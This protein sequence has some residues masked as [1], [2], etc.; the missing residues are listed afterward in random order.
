MSDLSDNYHSNNISISALELGQVDDFLKIEFDAF[1]DSFRFIYSN[2]RDAAYNIQRQEI[3]DNLIS[4]R[5]YN[6]KDGYKVVGTI[7]LVTRENSKNYKKKFQ[8]FARYLGILRAIKAY[9]LDLMDLPHLDFS[10]VYID[11]VAVD[12]ENRRK[13]I[14]ARMLSFAEDYAEK[15]GKSTLRLWVASANKEAHRLYK[16]MGYR[17]LMTRSS[18]MGEKYFG[19]RDWEFMGKD[20]S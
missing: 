6:A 12:T 8:L 2:R 3:L 1:Y 9:F 19:Y 16:R 4:G 15:N 11:N 18:R 10:T 7:E 17:T 20:I 13:G 5:Y 14:A